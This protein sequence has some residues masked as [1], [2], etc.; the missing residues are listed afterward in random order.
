M[1][2]DEKKMYAPLS[3]YN[4]WLNLN[5]GDRAGTLPWYEF[6]LTSDR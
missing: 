3:V 4:M 6:E 2:T 5:K 1:N